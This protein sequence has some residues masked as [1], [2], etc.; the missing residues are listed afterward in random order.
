MSEVV[1]QLLA[2]VAILPRYIEGPDSGFFM[3]LNFYH[4]GQRDHRF[5]IA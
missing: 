1:V 5:H 3:L 4:I 2:L